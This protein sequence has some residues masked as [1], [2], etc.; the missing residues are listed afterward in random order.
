MFHACFFVIKSHFV[1]FLSMLNFCTPYCSHL[2]L[3]LKTWRWPW[4]VIG[5][6]INGQTMRYRDFFSYIFP[7]MFWKGRDRDSFP[8]KA[9]SIELQVK[10]SVLSTWKC[11]SPADVEWQK[12]PSKLVKYDQIQIRMS[13]SSKQP[14]PHTATFQMALM[15]GFEM[16]HKV[17]PSYL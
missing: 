9:L 15:Q 8:N 2:G 7:H 4:R 13:F 12:C 5:R 3:Y 1:V 6:E 14:H 10:I 11:P 17:V 16:S